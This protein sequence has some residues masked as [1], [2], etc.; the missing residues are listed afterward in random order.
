VDG[1]GKP[2]SLLEETLVGGVGGFGGEF[3]EQSL[4]E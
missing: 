2:L 3:G 1:G 4:A